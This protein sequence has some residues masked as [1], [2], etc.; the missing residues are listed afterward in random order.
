MK[1]KTYFVSGPGYASL[2]LELKLLSSP[3]PGLRR[4]VLNLIILFLK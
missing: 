4:G 3:I 2:K 1:L